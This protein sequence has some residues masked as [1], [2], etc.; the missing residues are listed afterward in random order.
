MKMGIH[1]HFRHC[2]PMKSARQSRKNIKQLI[3]S[4]INKPKYSVIPAQAGIQKSI[5]NIF[6]S[7]Y[8]AKPERLSD[9]LS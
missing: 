3:M 1:L 4:A 8:F 9:H 7:F 5:Q 6:N 2:E